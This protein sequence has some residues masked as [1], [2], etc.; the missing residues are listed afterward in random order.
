MTRPSDGLRP[1]K[2]FDPAQPALLHDARTGRMVTWDWARAEDF[3]RRASF[4][5]DGRVIFDEEVFD[6]WD[7]VLG[8]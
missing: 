2:K 5:P 3:R 6:G 7:D 8:G 1:M 4:Q